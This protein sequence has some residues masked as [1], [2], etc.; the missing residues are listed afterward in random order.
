[1]AVRKKKKSQIELTRARILAQRRKKLQ[2]K[3]FHPKEKSI[4]G[5]TAEFLFWAKEKYPYQIVT[6]EEITQ[7]IFSLGSVPNNKSPH[8]KSVRGQMSSVGKRLLELFKVSLI[9]ERGVGARASVDDRDILEQSVTK[10]AERTS[11]AAAKLK[12][13]SDLVSPEKLSALLEE[14]PNGQEKDDFLQL[15]TW[16]KEDLIK[17]VKKLE[18]PKQ[19]AALLPPPTTA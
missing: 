4:R 3:S 2:I 6:Y 18:Q 8:V 12:K 17:L 7:A 10:E 14:L 11:L 5:R 16:F 13:V 15:S 1:M 19:K 9:T